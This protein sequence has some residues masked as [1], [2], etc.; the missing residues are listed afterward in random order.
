[1]LYY[2]ISIHEFEI[3]RILQRGTNQNS[4]RKSSLA[5][6]KTEAYRLRKVTAKKK[7]VKTPPVGAAKV[8]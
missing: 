4:K 5:K 8:T 1:M 6:K 2:N 7:T 3:P